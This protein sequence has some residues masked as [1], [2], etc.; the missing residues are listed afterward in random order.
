MHTWD[1][2]GPMPNP[3]NAHGLPTTLP[4]I[5]QY[6]MDMAYTAPPGPHET[7]QKLNTAFT[8]CC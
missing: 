6:D 4:Y 1:L 3:P 2:T 5:R 8:G 7:M